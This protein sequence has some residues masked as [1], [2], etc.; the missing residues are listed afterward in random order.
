MLIGNEHTHICKPYTLFGLHTNHT[1]ILLQISISTHGMTQ[2]H[3]M[4]LVEI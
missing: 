1:F 4:R 2:R 3:K